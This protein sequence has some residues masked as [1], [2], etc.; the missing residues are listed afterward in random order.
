[1]ST[2]N[3]KRR[4]I[5][6]FGANTFSRLSTTLTQILSVPVF[7]THWGPHL[8]GEWILLNAIPAYFGLSDVGF[9]SVAGNEMTML[10]AAQNLDEALV[11]FQSVWVLTTVISGLVGLLLI[12]AIWFIPLDRWLHVNSLSTHDVRLIV[13]L[14]GL[15]VLLGMQET[16]FQSAFRCVGKYPL[17]TMAK[18]IVVLA[19]FLSTIIGV[20]LGLR[21]V[22]VTILYTVTNVLGVFAL[23]IL[24]RR[25]VP[26]IRF[27]VEHARWSSIRRLTS[28][29][30]SF[31]SFPVMNALN[32]QGV[33]VVVGHAMGPIAVVTFNTART[34]SRSA[35]QGMNLINNSI[36]PEVSAAFGAGDMDL[37]RKLHRRACQLSILLCLSIIA[38]ITLFGN[39]IWRVWTVGKIPTD[40]VLLYIMLL[41][42]LLSSF[43][44]TSSVVP[45]AINKHQRMAR[46]MLAATALALLLAWVL[47]RV[48][49]L[50][51]R[52][53]AIGLTV[54][55]LLTALYVIRESL[56]LLDDN[57]SGFL[58]SML[59][60]SLFWRLV[61]RP[62]LPMATEE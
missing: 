14:L 30:L 59:D 62:V 7:L 47:M 17:G 36:W 5:A 20:M 33:L 49:S 23:W 61:R 21:P 1:M 10:A 12:G 55:D 15:A 34:I 43:W 29:A 51:L 57:L 19:A 42:M 32:L 46:A 8:Y 28:P 38:V 25:E 18:S 4:L 11:V 22:P 39:W 44:F 54:G 41:Q 3:L 16:L 48:P 37:A 52:G 24:L 50:G 35:A 6:G 26:W 45:L 60:L 13:L 53:A 58:G 2:S 9:G 27:G 31:M 56:R 40:P